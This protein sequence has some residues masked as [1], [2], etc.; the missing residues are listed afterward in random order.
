MSFHIRN[1]RRDQHGV[2]LLETAIALP[3]FMLLI[4]GAVDF[5]RAWYVSIEIASASEAGVLYG[6]QN[7]SDTVGM[8]SAA[9]LGAPNVS[10]LNVATY[11]CEC[12]DGTN[13]KASCSTT[14]SCSAT[15]NVVNYVQVKAN[16]TYVPLIP[17]PGLPASFAISNTSRLRAGQ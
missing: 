17:Y 2:T 5:G 10:T 1:F 6:L 16:S 3:L 9:A 13:A 14:P 7:I 11:G 8:Q 15:S 4:V 12:S